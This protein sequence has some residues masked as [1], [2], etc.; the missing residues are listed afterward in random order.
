[1]VRKSLPVYFLRKKKSFTLPLLYIFHLFVQ[2]SPAVF[3]HPI[4]GA[5]PDKRIQE[6]KKNTFTSYTADA[7]QGAKKY[8]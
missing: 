1:M 2:A 4:S 8:K 3:L 6:K 7:L 5:G